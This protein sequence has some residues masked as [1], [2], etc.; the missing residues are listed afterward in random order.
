MTPHACFAVNESSQVGAARRFAATVA[1]QHGFD[2]VAAGRLALVINELGNNLVLHAREG[3]LLVAALAIGPEQV[4]EVI[5]I[6]R[7]PGMADTAR[8]LRDGFSTAGTPGSGLGAVRRLSL[9]FDIFSGADQGTVVV[10]R[11][12]AR[13][14]G[15]GGGRTAVPPPSVQIAGVCIAAPGESVSGDSW[16]SRI[17]STKSGELIVADGLGHGPDA[18]LA[19]DAAI[20]CFARHP[21]MPPRDLLDRAHG[22]LRGTRGAALA[23]LA[24]DAEAGEVWLSGAGNIAGRLVSGTKDRSMMTPH[25]TAGVQMRSAQALRYEW[26]EHAVVILHSDGIASR[27]TLAAVPA[28][29]GCSAIVIAAWILHHH[30]RGRDDATVVVLRRVQA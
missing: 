16:S 2:E 22:S 13:G 24:F 14:G 26:E 8:C 19:A 12:A 21:G 30:L 23:V 6:D 4:V 29:L 15:G 1:Q 10:A 9:E 5:S 28:L 18:A 20:D 11:I 7:G 25:G 27:W 3:Q 17:A